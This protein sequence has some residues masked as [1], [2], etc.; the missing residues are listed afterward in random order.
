MMRAPRRQ[1]G[2]TMA[3]LLV[4]MT[5]GLVVLLAGARLLAMANAAYAGQI[6]LAEVDE[7]GRY[8]LATIG[9]AVRQAAF[10]DWEQTGAAGPGPAGRAA[11]AGLDAHSISKTSA[12]IDNPLPDSVN[13]SDVLA[14][15]LNGAGAAPD[16]DGSVVSCAGSPLHRNEDGWSIFYVAE[17]AQGVAELR[18]KYRGPGSW[19]ADAVIAGV[20]SFQVL[21]GLDTDTPADGVANR[22]VNAGIVGGLDAAL[23][24]AGAS[25]A[26]REQDRLR[27]THW[28][29]VV[30][31]RI[32][33]LLHSATPHHAERP[34]RTWHLFGAPYTTAA[35]VDDPGTAFN[36]AAQAVELRTRERKLFESTIALPS[37]PL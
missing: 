35:G 1:R 19:G 30:S 2:L 5:L 28:K 7:G 22:Y 32:A 29:R 23:V 15:R 36:E 3:E 14:V 6:G 8:A 25:A 12:G 20:D 4:A 11:L 34:R 17:N 16:G 24:L 33:L 26:E 27:R 21:Y 18:C 9:H 37:R 31:V 13:G 10:V